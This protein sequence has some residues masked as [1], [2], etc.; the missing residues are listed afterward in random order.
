MRVSITKSKTQINKFDSYGSKQSPKGF[1][2]HPKR[3]AFAR[4]ENHFSINQTLRS[5][6][7]VGHIQQTII[8][9]A[10]PRSCGK[11]NAPWFYDDLL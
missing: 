4:N 9:N 3:V 1:I 10:G 2:I 7:P 5:N 6:I 11:T 8:F